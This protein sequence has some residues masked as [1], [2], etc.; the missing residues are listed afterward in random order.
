MN[1]PT[2]Y[3]LPEYMVKNKV[4]W[5]DPNDCLTMLDYFAAK[6]PSEIPEWFSHNEPENRPTP[7]FL[8]KDAA[9]WQL[10]DYN[11]RYFQWRWYY[12]Q[13]MLKERENWLK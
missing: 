7:K 10:T 3:P 12:A 5:D 2:V 4:G 13:Q 8:V 11:A 1:N 6:A 9:D